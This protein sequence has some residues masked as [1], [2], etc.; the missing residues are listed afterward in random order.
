MRRSWRIMSACALILAAA[1]M[2]LSS[3]LFTRIQDERTQTIVGACLRDSDQSRAIIAFLID[4]HARPST[5]KSSKSFFPVL[6][7]EQCEQRGRNLV[8]P[9]PV[10]R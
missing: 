8:G 1:S 10:K 3:Y 2:L 6:T 5:I 9:P 4:V 7:R